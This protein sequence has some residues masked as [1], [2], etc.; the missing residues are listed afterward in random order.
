MNRPKQTNCQQEPPY[1]GTF[2]VVF[3]LEDPDMVCHF[4]NVCRIE[5]PHL[6]S[7]CVEFEQN[8]GRTKGE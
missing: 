5:C 1:P 2:T 3:C 8:G 4:P 6:I 7:E